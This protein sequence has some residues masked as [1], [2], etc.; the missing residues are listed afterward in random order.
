MRKKKGSETLYQVSAQI[1]VYY[2]C[3]LWGM[4]LDT[5]TIRTS[6]QNK[7]MFFSEGKSFS[8]LRMLSPDPTH[9]FL[10]EEFIIW[11]ALTLVLCFVYYVYTAIR[12]EVSKRITGK[13][14]VEGRIKKETC[15]EMEVRAHQPSP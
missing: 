14:N 4:A 10:A 5:F 11:A 6:P 9:S 12:T 3:L 2:G 1:H 13:K 15:D 8:F 7:S